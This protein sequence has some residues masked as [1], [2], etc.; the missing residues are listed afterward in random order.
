MSNSDTRHV[1]LVVA[2]ISPAIITEAFYKLRV[3]AQIP[4]SEIWIITTAVGKQLVT[5]KLLA[6]N[7][8]FAQ[9]CCDYH[10][11]D[12]SVRFEPDT[13]VVAEDE[14]EQPLSDVQHDAENRAFP[15]R[16]IRLVEQLTADPTVVLHACL[17]GGR[18]SMS[19]YLGAAMMMLGRARDELI[20]VII[21]RELELCRPTFYYP[22]RREVIGE[23]LING[24]TYRIDYRNAR[25]TLSRIPFLRLRQTFPVFQQGYTYPELVRKIQERVNLLSENRLEGYPGC[26]P[27]SA[28]MQTIL[29]RARLLPPDEVVLITGETGTG[30][31]LM[32]QYIHH[33]HSG[34]QTPYVAVNMS[35]M[36]AELMSAALFG[37][38]KGAFTGALS[39][40][41]GYFDA[42]QGG[43]IF[44]DEVDKLP[45]TLQGTLLRV[46][47]EKRYHPVGSVAEKEVRCRIVIGSNR[48]LPAL[49]KSGEFF[50]DLYYR[51]EAFQL[52]LPPL[53]ERPE[54][55]PVLANY[56]FAKYNLAY[57]KSIE[58]IP[59]EMLHRWQREPWPGN[60][61]ELEN[62]IKRMVAFS[63]GTSLVDPNA[64]PSAG[65]T[66][67]RHLSRYEREEAEI[68]YRALTDAQ[69]NIARAARLLGINYST[70]RSRMKKLGIDA[71]KGQ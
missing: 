12:K 51:M 3:E 66:D 22:T 5:E 49:V 20:H 68:I 16:L 60:I 44:L 56:F 34:A 31:E 36:R 41:P 47:Q 30:K 69:G 32:A 2:G 24:Q 33:L 25:I 26:P 21:S 29:Q 64:S 15:T 35:A 55:I 62:R 39:D 48:D 70:L 11:P 46:L 18:K 59:A 63:D 43:T 50:A 4:I 13:I 40:K 27:Q 45:L 42:A 53:R 71:A 14:F 57:G 65:A 9:L 28:A 67:A 54:D 58:T 1:L 23:A 17:S 37:Y 7:G 6:P 19:F 10:I 8:V 38:V 52:H 61:R